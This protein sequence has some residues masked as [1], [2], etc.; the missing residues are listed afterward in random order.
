[1]REFTATFVVSCES[2]EALRAARQLAIDGSRE[3]SV[4]TSVATV[5]DFVAIEKHRIGDY[6]TS[7]RVSGNGPTAFRIAFTPKPNADRYWKD[8]AVKIL[9]SIHNPGVSVRY[10]RIAPQG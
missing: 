10:E 1:M 7:I 6:F 2:P 4:H 5:R 3:D 9:A 8:L